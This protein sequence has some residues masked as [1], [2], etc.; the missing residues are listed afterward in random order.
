MIEDHRFGEGM[1]NFSLQLIS[2]SDDLTGCES[3]CEVEG[4]GAAVDF[5]FLDAALEVLLG[6]VFFNIFLFLIFLPE[7]VSKN[8]TSVPL[9]FNVSRLS[10]KRAVT[11]DRL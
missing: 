11:Q 9:T 4:V 8:T 3:P 1:C 10:F 5:S 6:F 7:M 2:R